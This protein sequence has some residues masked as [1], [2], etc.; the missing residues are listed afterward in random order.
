[1]DVR[2]SCRDG[3]AH[4]SLLEPAV[5][6]AAGQLLPEPESG[7]ELDN[8]DVDDRLLWEVPEAPDSGVLYAWL[9]GEA[10]VIKRLRRLLVSGYGVPRAAVAFMGYWRAGRPE[11]F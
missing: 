5:D 8:V 7:G 1:V 6:R 9:A 10:A 4:G 11:G 2:W 3:A